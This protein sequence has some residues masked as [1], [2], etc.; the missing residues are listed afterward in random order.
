MVKEDGVYFFDMF[1]GRHGCAGNEKRGG[2]READVRE[3]T[4][5][6]CIEAEYSLQ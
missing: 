4:D 3:E 2:F 5:R 6:L 1:T